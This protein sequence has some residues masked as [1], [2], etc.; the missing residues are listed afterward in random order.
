MLHVAVEISIRGSSATVTFS[1]IELDLPLELVPLSF[2]FKLGLLLG[3]NLEELNDF[4]CPQEFVAGDLV[5]ETVKIP[6]LL[7]HL[8]VDCSL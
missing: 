8:F 1:A 5:T 2:M 4:W 3:W 6:D 7:N